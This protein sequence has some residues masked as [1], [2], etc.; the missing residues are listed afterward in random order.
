MKTKQILTILALLAFSCSLTQAAPLGTAFTYQGRLVEGGSSA[1]GIYDVRFTIYD[2]ASGGSVSGVLTNAATPV[3]NGLF[4][5]TL[6]FGDGV[7]DGNVRWLEIGVRTN[8]GSAFTTLSPRQPLTPAPYALYAPNAGLANF[9]TTATTALIANGVAPGVVSQLGAPG[10]STNAVQ[11]NASGLVGIGTGASAPLAGL[12]ITAGAPVLTASI[13]SQE[14]D[15][16]GAYTNLS[17]PEH[18]AVSGNLLAVSTAGDS[19]VTLMKIDDP[20]N[21]VLL[22]QIWDGSGTFNNLAGAAG[23][24][25]AGSNLVVAAVYDN[26]VTIISATN[27][28]SP[29]K[30]AELRNGVGGW[31]NLEGAQLT[32]VSGNLLAIAT[33]YDSVTLADISNLSAP[34][35]RS[36][37]QNGINGFTNLTCLTCEALSGNLLV[38]G[39]A[40]DSAVTLV[41]VSNPSS[42]VKLAELR[43]G[44][45]G[46]ANLDGVSSVALKSANLLAIAARNS[47]AVTLV[48]VSNPSSPVK[49]AELRDGVDGF[50]L[51]NVW[52]VAFASDN[53]LAIA[54][55]AGAVTLVD[56]SNPFHPVLLTTVQNGVAGMELLGYPAVLAFAGANLVVG[57]DHDNTVTL[58]GF[59][60][61]PASL[62]TAGWVG[63]GTTHPL[64]PLDVV[65]NV[66]VENANVFDINAVNL[67]LGSQAVASGAN[68]TAIGTFAQ[69]NG[70]YSTALGNQA[71]ASGYGSVALGGAVASGGFATAMGNGAYA[72]GN[73]S[74][75]MGYSTTAS[76]GGSTAMGGNT[77]A[78]GN[79]STAMGLGTEAGGDNSTAMGHFTKAGGTNSMAA[80]YRAKATNDD[81]F[82][83]GDGTEADIGSTAANQFIIRA[84]G[85]VGIGTNNPSGFALNVAGDTRVNGA[86]TANSLRAPG[87]GI[88]TGTFAFT[89]RAVGTNI[90]SNWTTI[91]NPLT[92]GDPNAIL[93]VTHNYSA[94]TNSTSPYN[95]E[96]VGVWYYAPH[97]TIYN[98]SNTHPMAPGR[99]FNVLVIKP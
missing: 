79:G 62:M 35:Q 25:W 22:S 12:Q 69:A 1:N 13:L 9:A 88:N 81:S 80:G 84:T 63:I 66:V 77:T 34:V 74:T 70:D 33:W 57:S 82:V 75:A 37:I 39:A 86:V 31:N 54:D 50:N 83:W 65:G 52:L 21:P 59:D 90:N 97:W 26:A 67:E 58:L 71:V 95:A 46:Y 29:V 8:G 44:V 60:T 68:S 92:D 19:A 28:A 45:G 17:Q 14:Q 18:L 27:P 5:V 24:A 20:S 78:S 76:G 41:N 11:V 49:L 53:R 10:G 55:Y 51:E 91:Y 89:H 47:G 93:I 42:P 99:A 73:G 72:S 56:V 40:C 98:E 64:A 85:G 43:N 36:C 61:Q 7:F 16:V 32:A 4:T 2:A 48:D 96:P 3:T 38:I 6:D 87:A 94:D 23:I 15:G 30:L